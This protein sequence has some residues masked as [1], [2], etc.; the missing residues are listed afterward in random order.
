MSGASS[1]TLPHFC[2]KGS[3]S[4]L[5]Y[6]GWKFRT[7]SST[8]L[9]RQHSVALHPDRYVS[10]HFL[11]SAQFQPISLPGVLEAAL[12][13][14]NSRG[15]SVAI[16]VQRQAHCKRINIQLPG[17]SVVITDLSARKQVQKSLCSK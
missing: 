6:A 5:P 11:E 9:V 10:L 3:G 16:L 7:D 17:I 2:T 12:G 4:R 15:H 1:N 8:T 13:M 14:R